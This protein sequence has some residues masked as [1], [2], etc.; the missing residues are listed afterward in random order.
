MRFQPASYLTFC[1]SVSPVLSATQGIDGRSSATI[2]SLK[3]RLRAECLVSR[4]AGGETPGARF[5]N[6]FKFRDGRISSLHIYL[7]PDYTDE[8]EARFRWVKNRN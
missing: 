8:D 7:D 6:V 1:L 2:S 4:G 5:C 3:A